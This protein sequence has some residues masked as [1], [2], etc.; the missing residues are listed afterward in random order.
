MDSVSYNLGRAVAPPVS[1]LLVTTLVFG[2]AFAANAVSFLVFAVCLVL[3]GH[4]QPTE[5]RERSQLRDGF[6]VSVRD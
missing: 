5:R 3:A 6:K 2:W 4:G 1:V